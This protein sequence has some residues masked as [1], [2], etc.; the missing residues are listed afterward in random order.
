MSYNIKAAEF[1]IE[2]KANAIEA[3]T[4]RNCLLQLENEQLAQD[5]AE[6]VE[7]L[8]SLLGM[9]SDG[10]DNYRITVE[11]EKLLEKHK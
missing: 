11:C 6:L 7:A 3:L 9:G 4:E 8:D 5:K 1:D 2:R 10:I